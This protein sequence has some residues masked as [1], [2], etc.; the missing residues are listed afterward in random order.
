MEPKII[1]YIAF[2]LAALGLTWLP[3]IRH[4]RYIGTPIIY[5]LLAALLFSL[6]IG[7]AYV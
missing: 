6:Q 5:V 1:L 2:G 3:E 4:I 7:R